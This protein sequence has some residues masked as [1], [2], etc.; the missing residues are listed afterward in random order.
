MTT[1]ALIDDHAIFCD[2]LSSLIN[3]FEDFRVVWCA[4]D[5][6]RAIQLLQ[7]KENVTESV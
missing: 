1:I 7:R 6:E 2:S 4:N 3:D 5:G